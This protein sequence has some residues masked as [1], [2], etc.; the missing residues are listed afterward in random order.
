MSEKS[1]NRDALVSRSVPYESPLRTALNKAQEVDVRAGVN[2]LNNAFAHATRATEGASGTSTQEII[3]ELR[4]GKVVAILSVDAFEF[5][6]EVERLKISC[7]G[8]SMMFENEQC[9]MSIP[10]LK[11][12]D[13]PTSLLGR[14]SQAVIDD[15][16]ASRA[17]NLP[18]PVISCARCGSNFR[19]SESD[20]LSLCVECGDKERLSNE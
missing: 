5:M 4:A 10:R 11:L 8:I 18:E 13:P 2:F 15:H 20:W 14:V 9:V 17:T 12:S 7:E 6:R 16:N 19:E 3:D 1:D